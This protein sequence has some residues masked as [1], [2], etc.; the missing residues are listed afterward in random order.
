MVVENG[1][2]LHYPTN[3][4]LNNLNTSFVPKQK[5]T[6]YNDYF[7]FINK[8]KLDTKPTN[9]YTK[10]TFSGMKTQNNVSIFCNFQFAILPLT[11]SDFTKEIYDVRYHKKIIKEQQ[12]KINNL[13]IE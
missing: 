1:N 12:T 9:K 2:L 3:V 4:H 7:Y 5:S 6:R 10:M 8:Y 13:E 11:A